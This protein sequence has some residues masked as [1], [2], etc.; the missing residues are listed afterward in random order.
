MNCGCIC[1]RNGGTLLP[2]KRR[3]LENVAVEFFA[4]GGNAPRLDRAAGLVEFQFGDLLAIDE[5]LEHRFE[6]LAFCLADGLALGAECVCVAAAE[7]ETALGLALSFELCAMIRIELVE[8]VF[9]RFLV[10]TGGKFGLGSLNPFRHRARELGRGESVPAPKALE[11]GGEDDGSLQFAEAIEQMEMDAENRRDPA[12]QKPR[13]V[14]QLGESVRG[15][16]VDRAV[17]RQGERFAAGEHA[18]LKDQ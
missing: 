16:H 1:L 7:R 8:F 17:V 4:A 11:V 10:A 18:R 14:K 3:A 2:S 5:T 15:G 13:R 12:R 6:E 9:E